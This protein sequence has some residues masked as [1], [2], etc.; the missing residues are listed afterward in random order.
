MNRRKNSVLNQ[1]ESK[2]DITPETLYNLTKLMEQCA[3]LAA[4]LE[5]H[6]SDPSG[7]LK[8]EMKGVSDMAKRHKQRVKIGVNENGDSVYKWADGY[9][10]DELNDNI[11]RIY[12]ENGLLDRVKDNRP[13]TQK[14]DTKGECPTFREYVEKWFATYKEYRLKPTTVKGYRSNLSRHI[15]PFFGDKRLDEITT[16]D[17]QQFLNEK[18][19]LARNTVHTMLVLIGEVLTSAYEDKLIP[20]DPSKSKRISIVSRGRKERNALKPEQLK[21][22][23]EGIATELKDDDERRLISLMLFTGMRRGEVLGLKW[24]DIDFKKKLIHVERSVTYAH[25]QPEVTTPKTAS[26]KRVIPLDERLEVFLQPIRGTGFILGGETP[27]TNMVFRRLYKSIGSKINLFGATPHVFRH[28][29]ITTLVK[30]DVDLKTIQRISGHANIST[31]LNIYTHTREEEIQEAGA[32]I[33]KLLG[34]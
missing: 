31:T 6:K 32:K 11:V 29:Y 9:S 26:G 3:P 21:A 8:S 7:V 19:S 5:N 4:L 27:L 10:I 1:S 14:I 25:N 12:I 23:I 22:I 17:I 13:P 24:E 16:D 15:Y 34:A 30:A 2:V 20:V 28:S 33:G 18:E